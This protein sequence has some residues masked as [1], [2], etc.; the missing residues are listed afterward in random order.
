MKITLRPTQKIPVTIN[1]GEQQL[2]YV[3]RN[4]AVSFPQSD[5]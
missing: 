2:C 3:G 5:F 1:D 4:R